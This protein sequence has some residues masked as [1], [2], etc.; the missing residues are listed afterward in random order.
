MDTNDAAIRAGV[1]SGLLAAVVE[2]QQALVSDR[3]NA[4]CRD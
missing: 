3:E 4:E 2:G 1:V